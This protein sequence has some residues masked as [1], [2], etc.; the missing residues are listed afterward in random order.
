MDVDQGKCL[1]LRLLKK[2]IHEHRQIGGVDLAV[3]DFQLLEMVGDALFEE[4]SQL[5][6]TQSVQRVCL[7][8]D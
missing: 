7:V 8:D 4:R 1:K 2:E 5:L 3:D 6:E